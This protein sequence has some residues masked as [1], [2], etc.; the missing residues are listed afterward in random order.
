M[1]AEELRQEYARLYNYMSVSR[2]PEYMKAFG[3]VMTEMYDWFADNKREAAEEWLM[4]L[5]A[6]KWRNYLTPTEA[7]EAV[8]GMTPKAPWTRE[9]WQ[10]AMAQHGY[11]LEEEPAYNRCALWV[12]MN[13]IMSDSAQTLGKYVEDSDMFRV[14]HDLAVD[15]LTD[16]DSRF[17]VRTYFGL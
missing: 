1:T 4:K 10:S 13:M 15:K 7:E 17:N 9:Q 5:E 8:N 16:E 14:V 6:I 2:N 3:K 11:E 12:V